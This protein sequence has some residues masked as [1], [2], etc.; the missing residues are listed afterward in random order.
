MSAIDVAVLELVRELYTSVGSAAPSARARIQ[1]P[2]PFL[3][4]ESG[5][6]TAPKLP[7]HESIKRSIALN[8]FR[9]GRCLT[10]CALRCR[11]ARDA[12]EDNA[13]RPL[14][15]RSH[16]SRATIPTTATTTTTRLASTTDVDDFRQRLE[17]GAFFL[18]DSGNHDVIACDTRQAAQHAGAAL[19]AAVLTG[20]RR[21]VIDCRVDTFDSTSRRR[22]AAD[23]TARWIRRCANEVA[24]FFET[25][26][27]LYPQAASGA[28]PTAAGLPVEP[29]L[30]KWGGS[31]TAPRTTAWHRRTASS[32]CR[33]PPLTSSWRCDGCT[34]RPW[35]RGRSSS[36]STTASRRRRPNS[37]RLRKCLPAPDIKEPSSG[38][39]AR[40]CVS[41][42]F[43]TDY[44]SPRFAAR[45][46]MSTYARVGSRGVFTF[47][48]DDAVVRAVAR[49]RAD[50][51]NNA[52]GKYVPL[53]GPPRLTRGASR[54]TTTDK[55]CLRGFES[56][57]NKTDDAVA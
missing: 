47:K 3:L 42:R 1:M 54:R 52:V 20:E 30:R 45:D 40:V 43:P 11:A 35:R 25:C 27:L 29:L 38:K 8:G 9:E 2:L 31:W 7:H 36:S 48:P 41:R 10:A 22:F 21:C 24:F 19:K 32:S 44:S 26:T 51:M 34:A 13:S 6:Q 12:A 15:L 49:Q 28:A 50:M 55:H 5:A 53:S 14:P 57:S 18:D 33:R 37:T 56:S 4:L 46:P 17:A 16:S 23:D 39:M